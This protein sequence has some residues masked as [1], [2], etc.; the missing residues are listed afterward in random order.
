MAK[1]RKIITFIPAAVFL[2]FIFYMGIRTYT[3][4]VMETV[5]DS[6]F[7]VDSME[8]LS[9]N[10]EGVLQEN[11]Y[12]D[13]AFI[14]LNGLATRVLGINY[15]NEEIKLANGQLTTEASALEDITAPKT[16]ALKL[17][18]FLS[19]RGIDF[20][21]MLAPAKQAYYNVEYAPGYGSDLKVSNDAFMEVL[22][23]AGINAI[24][25]NV[26][27]EENEWDMK[28]VYFDTDHHWKPQAALAAANEAM[29]MLKEKG[30]IDYYDKELLESDSYDIVTLEDWFLGSNGKRTGIYYAG[31]DDIDVYLPKFDTDYSYSGLNSDSTNWTYS[32][33]PLNL[34][35]MDSKDYSKDPYS[36]Y[37]YGDYPLQL[38]TNEDAPIDK[39]VLLFGDS[40]KKPYNY[41]LSTQFKRIYAIDLRHYTDGSLAQFIGE[42]Q[43]DI[44]LM[45][46]NSV[47]FISMVTAGI[48]AYEDAV[49]ATPEETVYEDI[50]TDASIEAQ[51]DNNKNFAVMAENLERGQM[52]TL[53][54][55]STEYVGDADKY[56]QMTL[57][58]LTTNTAVYNRYFDAN[59]DEPQ[60]WIFDVPD[61]G[62]SYAIYFYAGTR[63]HTEGASA[64]VS[65]VT[66]R[67]GIYED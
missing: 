5:T 20:V 56:V 8:D 13:D 31:V 42:I 34:T 46:S 6:T 50:L 61:T 25:M 40:Y 21:Y 64:K 66:L 51:E 55:E 52:Y 44:V 62:D 54:L 16:A 39:T 2:G 12:L 24:D 4:T 28:D 27:F 10:F 19:D 1:K 38:V 15:L 14:N 49:D 32:D 63:A 37:L 59:S 47:G 48:N 35:Y 18:S 67:K 30:I 22:D 57:Q 45:C 23:D 41:F 53:T 43:P 29:Q 9:D 58:D 60:K 11:F 33:F 17:D 7:T 3:G 36:M 65:G 26:W